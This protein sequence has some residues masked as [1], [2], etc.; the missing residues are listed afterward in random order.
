MGT[1]PSFEGRLT[2]SDLTDQELWDEINEADYDLN[3][4]EAEFHESVGKRLT[5]GVELTEKQHDK[6]LELYERAV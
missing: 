6:L 4:W 2:M 5:A 3:S 1:T